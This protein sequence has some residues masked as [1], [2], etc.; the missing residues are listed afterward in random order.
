VRLV[1]SSVAA[2]IAGLALCA[3]SATASNAAQPF[4]GGSCQPISPTRT[5]CFEA[6]G[7]FQQK[8]SGDFI[9]LAQ[10]RFTEYTN[11][12]VT[13]E[14]RDLTHHVVSGDGRVSIS[15]FAGASTPSGLT[16][17]W[18][19]QVVVVDGEV[20]HSVDQLSCS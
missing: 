6:W 16:C 13:F 14:Q 10:R 15:L 3:G 20:V 5:L 4:H 7:V 19:E 2:T 8:E 18:R 9:D 1:I 12:V 11:G 17:R